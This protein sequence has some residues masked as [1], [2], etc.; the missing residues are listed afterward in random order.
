MSKTPKKQKTPYAA[1]T[2]FA[3]STKEIIIEDLK[4]VIAVIGGFIFIGLF[5]LIIKAMFTVIFRNDI[6]FS[7]FALVFL[8]FVKVFICLCF[9]SLIWGFM[10]CLS[11]TI[12]RIRMISKR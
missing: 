9:L 2:S 11:W 5:C 7:F 8:I 4:D 6:C 3:P 10:K 1:A 12:D